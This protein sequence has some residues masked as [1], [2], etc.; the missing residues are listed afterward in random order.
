[1]TKKCHLVG[2]RGSNPVVRTKFPQSSGWPRDIFSRVSRNT[3]SFPR[4]PDAIFPRERHR[5]ETIPHP[6]MLRAQRQPKESGQGRSTGKFPMLRSASPALSPVHRDR[7]RPRNSSMRSR[8]AGPRKNHRHWAG[9][10]ARTRRAS[11]NSNSALSFAGTPR[12]HEERN[13]GSG[14]PRSTCASTVIEPY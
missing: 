12:A 13:G 7:T 14:E 5:P 8:R 4:G 3:V 10:R 6:R 11:D 1:M 9:N 2:R